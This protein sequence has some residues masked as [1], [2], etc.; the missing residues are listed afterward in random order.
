MRLHIFT[1]I[2]TAPKIKIDSTPKEY[3]VKKGDDVDIKVNFT[4]YP[5][6]TDEWTVNGTI[7]QNNKRV[8]TFFKI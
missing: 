1:E 4:A 7:I 3:K 8:S 6:P 2:K 5:T